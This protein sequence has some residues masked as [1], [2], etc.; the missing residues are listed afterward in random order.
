M[1]M[2]S[3]SGLP[4]IFTLALKPAAL[5]LWVYLLGQSLVPL[6]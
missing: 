6:V 5:G 2:S 4:T 3:T 1:C